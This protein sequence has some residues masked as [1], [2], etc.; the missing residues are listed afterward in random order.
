MQTASKITRKARTRESHSR[1]KSRSDAR[2]QNPPPIAA[3]LL[4]SVPLFVS[5]NLKGFHSNTH[6]YS[7]GSRNLSTLNNI[8]LATQD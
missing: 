4:L 6:H 5:E 8:Y 2:E 3:D 7:L 1:R